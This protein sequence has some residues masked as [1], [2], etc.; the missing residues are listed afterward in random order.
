MRKITEMSAGHFT[1]KIYRDTQYDEYSVR[2]YRDNVL[3][4][5][6]D[7]FETD[8][9]SARGTMELALRMMQQNEK[10]DAADIDDDARAD[11]ETEE[12]NLRL[13]REFD[14]ADEAEQAR[15]D[16][17]AECL[18]PYR[19]QVDT[20]TERARQDILAEVG[21]LRRLIGCTPDGDI[22]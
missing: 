8:E 3:M 16:M 1:A 14:W 11:S 7:A 5:E 22:L 13:A 6:C 19:V 4:P 15:A 21:R 18:R 12:L 17:V 10:R 9:E 2:F 20:E